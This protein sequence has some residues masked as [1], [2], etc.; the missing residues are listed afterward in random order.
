MVENKVA[1]TALVTGVTG[2]DGAY[3]SELLLEKGYDVVGLRRRSSSFN[4]WTVTVPEPGGTVIVVLKPFRAQDDCWRRQS[5]C[6]CN[7]TSLIS[8]KMHL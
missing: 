3:L 5:H 4:T 6:T 8:A 2:Q 7:G 1:K